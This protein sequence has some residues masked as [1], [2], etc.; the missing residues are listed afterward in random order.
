[1]LKYIFSIFLL[2]I[3]ISSQGSPKVPA[4][5]EFAGIKLKI[6][7][8]ARKQIQEDVDALHKNQTYL[9]R[10]IEKID[11]FFPIIE[12]VFKEENLPDDFKYLTIQESALISDAVSSSNAVGFWQFKKASAIEVGLRVDGYVDERM[13]ITASSHA[14][15]KYI[16]KNNFFFNNWIYAL[17]AYNTGPTGAKEHIDN[18]YLG[19]NK[20][21]IT[22]Q[23]HWYVKK[24]L[25]HKIAFENEIHKNYTPALILYEYENTQ[26]KSLKD[27]S[28]HFDMDLQTIIDYNKWLRKGKIPSDKIYYAIIPMSS[29]DLVAQNLPESN[30]ESNQVENLKSG[31]IFQSSYEAISDFDF[32]INQQFP[33]I[34]ENKGSTK[35]KI[36]GIPGFVASSSD[37]LNAILAKF[38]VSESKFL[39]YNDMTVADKIDQ[40]KVYYLRAKKSKAKIH[41]HVVIPGENAWSISQKYGL[42]IKKLLAKNRMKEE[43]EL[44]QGMVMW[45]RFIRPANVPVEYKESKV[46]NM[47]IKSVPNEIETSRPI[48]QPEDDRKPKENLV[49]EDAKPNTELIETIYL[50]EEINDE[51]DFINENSYVVL[52]KDSEGANE[53]KVGNNLTVQES[54]EIINV[55]KEDFYHIVKSSETLFSIS[56]AYSVTVEELRAWNHL[57]EQDV[58]DIGQSLLIKKSSGSNMSDE[59]SLA[60]NQYKTHTVKQEDTLYSIARQYDISIK[61]LMDLNNKESF[62]IKEGE[63][64]KI[65]AIN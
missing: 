37:N 34:S 13:H 18:K 45:L 42:K 65:K 27:I 12:R 8:A 14:A 57:N 39:K 23:T 15:A 52:K 51:T 5:Y 53:E 20:M 40:G 1:M 31:I 11:L 54:N 28:D 2:F 16:K 48:F 50:F 64:L 4:D 9:R 55:K 46:Q 38:G 33:K 59:N 49:V 47:V 3:F 30:D 58:L 21:D 61:E 19:K 25:A 29:Q 43:K 62:T 26:N 36:N 32:N 7:E 24:F 35:V 56:G 22:K 6:S 60:V 44:S 17:L 10:R 63:E 41:Y